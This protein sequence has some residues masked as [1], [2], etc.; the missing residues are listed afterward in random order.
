LKLTQKKNMSRTQSSKRSRD[1]YYDDD[2]NSSTRNDHYNNDK[3]YDEDERDRKQRRISSTHKEDDLMGYTNDQNP[4][5]D[6]RLT[7]KFVWKKASSSKHRSQ[8]EIRQELLKA[9]ERRLQREQE[10]REEEEER[11]RLARERERSTYTEWEKKEEEFHLKQAKLRTDIR[12]KEGRAKPID[13]IAKNLK[14]LD[15]E[16]DNQESHE[17]AILS[18]K[19]IDIEL[20][21]PYLIFEGLSLK[22]LEELKVDIKTHL[23]LDKKMYGFWNALVIVCDNEIEKAKTKE[24]SGKGTTVRAAIN[25]SVKQSVEELFL[26]KSYNQLEELEKEIFHTTRNPDP[27]TDVEYWE[28]LLKDLVVFKAKALLREFHVSLLEKHLEHVNDEKL[29]KDILA[30]KMN[31]MKQSSTTARTQPQPQSKQTTKKEDFNLS[32]PDQLPAPSDKKVFTEEE[33]L[34]V[35]QIDY[36]DGDDDFADEIQLTHQK[37]SWD[38]KY[39]PRKPKYFNR[40]HTGYEWNKYNQVHYDTDKPPPKTIQGYKF[41]VFFPDL[42]DKSK[43]P[44]WFLEP[45]KSPDTCI[46]RFHAGPPY[47][48]IAFKIVNRE[49]ERSHSRGYRCTFERGILHL[50]FRF[51]RYKYRR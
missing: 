25:P 9:K 51:K 17:D 29:K 47:E 38:D 35:A 46:I 31:K 50:Y 22:D 3:R 12:L 14:L 15:D 26:G 37:Y 40:V 18:V 33:M 27:Y 11:D 10:Q 2:R 21:E 24:Q 23:D 32:L 13:L 20:R 44:Q 39:R 28:E 8:E 45:G 19:D 16:A 41:N 4:F 42:I 49:W 7:E 48:D 1:D 5:N 34:R 6:D 30:T 36:E 43:P